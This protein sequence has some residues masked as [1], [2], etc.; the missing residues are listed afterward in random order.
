MIKLGYS[1]LFFLATS[2]LIS[3]GIN[4]DHR[5]IDS[6]PGNDRWKWFS[7]KT[8]YQDAFDALNCSLSMNLISNRSQMP[9]NCRANSVVLISRHA[10]R[11]PDRKMIVEMQI[12]LDRLRSSLLSNLSN[13]E[14]IGFDLDTLNELQNWKLQMNAKHGKRIVDYGRNEARALGKVYIFSSNFTIKKLIYFNFLNKGSRF[15]EKYAD[16]LEPQSGANVSVGVTFKIRTKETAEEFFAPIKIKYPSIK[17][18]VCQNE[19]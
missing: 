2:L 10:T 6:N 16:L 3:C 15:A 11:L 7:T 17:T 9:L 12:H 4:A 14:S 8:V 18:T 1:W 19:L 13:L 5:S